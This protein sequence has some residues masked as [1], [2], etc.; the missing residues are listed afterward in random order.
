M[1]CSLLFLACICAA[2]IE[3]P[4]FYIMNQ[5]NKSILCKV[6]LEKADSLKVSHFLEV[7]EGVMGC[8]PDGRDAPARVNPNFN[9]PLL[10]F[11]F[12]R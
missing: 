5:M 10:N 11:N 9:V 7:L 4:Y 12:N 1:N 6:D 2:Q 8:I 3:K